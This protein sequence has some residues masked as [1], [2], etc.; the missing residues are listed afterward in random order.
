MSGFTLRGRVRSSV[1][2]ED[3]D[4]KPLLL[5]IERSQFRWHLLRT[6]P[7][8]LPLEVYRTQP[9]GR[10]LRGR[11]R[12][13]LKDHIF[14]H[15]WE[16]L[17]IPQEELEEVAGESNPEVVRN[18]TATEITT[19]SVSLS[20]TEPEGN[21]SFYRVEWTDGRDNGSH[22]VNKTYINITQLTAGVQYTFT[23]IAVA[24]DKETVGVAS[25]IS[26]YT[27]PEVVRN[28]TVTEITTSSVSLSWTE[29]EGN[30]S[31]Y[32]VEWTDGRAS[33]S[34]N[35]NKTY[36]N[37]TQLTAGVQYQITITAVAGDGRTEG[38]SITVFQYASE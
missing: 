9:T 24:G 16:C 28:L 11:P 38:Q 32:R 25:N 22:S 30:S 26:L 35:V 34:H 29:P 18:L 10:R 7:G 20:W 5:H 1:T 8:H 13:Y 12:T 33:G 23:V 2:W 4:V 19:S 14:Q 31:F 36:I 27:K 37:I 15:P 3:L 17:G 6:P 21:S